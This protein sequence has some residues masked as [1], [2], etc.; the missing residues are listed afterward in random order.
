MRPLANPHSKPTTDRDHHPGRDTAQ[1]PHSGAAA[2]MNMMVMPVMKAAIEPTERSRP[3]EEITK[4]APTAMMATKAL[5]VMTLL[6]LVADRKSGLMRKPMTSS[7]AKAKNGPD[8]GP[9]YRL[10]FAPCGRAAE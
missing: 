7:A 5:R 1:P 4:V 8:V 10:P 6:R 3:P 2:F 9:A